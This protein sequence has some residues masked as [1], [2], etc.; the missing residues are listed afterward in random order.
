MARHSRAGASASAF[1]EPLSSLA[2]ME[3]THVLHVTDRVD[4]N[5][6]RASRIL[7]IS[8][9]HLYRLLRKYGRPAGE[10]PGDGAAPAPD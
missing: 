8:E 9:R 3:R 1:E 7:G 6:G 10:P 4:G 5:R 2:E